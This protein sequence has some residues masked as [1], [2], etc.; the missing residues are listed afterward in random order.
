MQPELRQEKENEIGKNLFLR[1]WSGGV[2]LGLVMS[3]MVM[4]GVVWCGMVWFGK[5]VKF[6]NEEKNDGTQS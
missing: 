6:E 2:R 1:F 5:E 4:S 3:G